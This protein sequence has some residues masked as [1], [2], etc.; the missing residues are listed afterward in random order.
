M[1]SIL[2]HT[3]SMSVSCFMGTFLMAPNA[4]AETHT[5]QFVWPC[6]QV[7]TPFPFLVLCSKLCPLNTFTNHPLGTCKG[8]LHNQLSSSLRSTGTLP[9]L[10]AFISLAGLT[11]SWADSITTS[12]P[13]E[14]GK[15][16][17]GDVRMDS[18]VPG[19]VDRAGEDK[20]APPKSGG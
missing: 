19:Y 11:E 14:M 9:S 2:A 13:L 3:F 5:L 7:H 6:C 8:L 10:S 15:E 20:G 12:I 4:S 16:Q 18:Q 1:L 17:M